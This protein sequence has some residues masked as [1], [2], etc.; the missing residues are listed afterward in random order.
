ME[1]GKVKF[2]N[3]TKGFGFII[4]DGTNEEIFVHYSAILSDGYKTLDEGQAVSFDIV[5]DTRGKKAENVTVL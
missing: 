3:A 5:D 2:F 4:V 1:S